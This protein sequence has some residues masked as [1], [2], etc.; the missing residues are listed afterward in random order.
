MA[1]YEQKLAL[2]YAA[3]Q[4]KE[5]NVIDNS[6]SVQ[7]YFDLLKTDE[8]IEFSQDQQKY[9]YDNVEGL[10]LYRVNALSAALRD[11][12]IVD[13]N[14]PAIQKELTALLKITQPII[15]RLSKISKEI[16]TFDGLEIRIK[17][18]DDGGQ[19]T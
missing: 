17:G 10:L 15:E 7:E 16:Q 14:Y 8:Y 5:A 2:H 4:P 9:F 13:R 18:V 19:E 3:G 11:L 1:T 12:P 6:L